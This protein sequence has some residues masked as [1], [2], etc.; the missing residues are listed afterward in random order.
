MQAEFEG[1]AGKKKRRLQTGAA[2]AGVSSISLDGLVDGKSRIDAC[3]W[4][5][6]VL[7]LKTSD[8]ID[9]EQAQPYEEINIKPCKLLATA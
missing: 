6:E 5:F 4:F 1:N 2:H 9:L 8:Y 3:R 7:V